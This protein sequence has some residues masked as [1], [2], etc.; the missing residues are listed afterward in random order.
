MHDNKPDIRSLEAESYQQSGYFTADQARK[1][2]VSRQPLN[3]HIRQGRF[4]RVRRGLYR[5]W[6]FPGSQYDDIREK[7]MAVGMDKAIVSHESALL[8]LELSDNIPDKVHLLVP[9]R[10]R[11]L[12][13]PSG[14]VIHTHSDTEK[15]ATAWGDAMPITAPARTLVDVADKL[16][17]EQAA[18]AARQALHL[19]L[20]TRRQLEREAA[21]QRKTH[22]LETLLAD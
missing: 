3:H 10:Y 8:L 14:V 16:Q 9:R 1:H 6:G 5:V 15:V 17:P 22:V 21:R 18:M 2:G 11:G 4:E 13:R 7:W 20:L 12:R 19:G